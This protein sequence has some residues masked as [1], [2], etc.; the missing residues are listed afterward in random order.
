[1]ATPITSA[2]DPYAVALED[3]DM[4]DP[5]LFERNLAPAYFERLRKECPVHY[6]RGS[7]CGPFWSVTKYADIIGV[8]KNHKVF[9]ADSAHGG[10]L[11]G[12]E[13]WFKSDPD[14][15]LPM[16]IAMDPPRHDVQRKA[17]SPVVA[18]EN[19]KKMEV[20]IRASA[21]EILDSLP[22]DEPFN[23]VERVSIELTTRTLAVLFDFP[24]AEQRKLTRW[25]DVAMSIPGD[26][27]TTSWES[28]KAE[29]LEMKSC[30]ERLWRERKTNTGGFDLVS[31]LATTLDDSAMNP[32]EYMGNVVLLIVGGNDTTRNSLTGSVL[33]LNRFPDENTKLRANPDLIPNFVSEAIRWQTPVAHMKRTALEDIEIRGQK[34]RAGDKVVM[35]YVSGN[36][37]EEMFERPYELI[38][39]RARARNHLSFGFGLH[40]CVGNRLGELQ[41]RIAWEEILKHFAVVEVVGEP[42]RV[43]SNITMGYSDLPVRVK[44]Y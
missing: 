16:I 14:L 40:R 9:S 6:S 29:M 26:G 8:D 33:A 36:R 43:Y 34:I 39:D 30:F 22:E 15:K 38:A 12:Y 44:R 23:W 7:D 41:L 13:M 19:L 17:V 24:F 11:L 4:S 35:W 3:I 21:Q 28:R 1:M 27:I 31:M 25:S 20:G 2:G 32:D 10:H 42:V 18:A 5:S 37:D